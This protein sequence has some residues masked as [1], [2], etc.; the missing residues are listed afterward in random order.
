MRTSA[1]A[2]RLT[3]SSSIASRLRCLHVSK[4]WIV[5]AASTAA[6]MSGFIAFTTISAFMIPLSMEFGWQKTALSAAY[7]L[8][9]GGAALGGVLMGHVSDRINTRAICIFG[10]MVLGLGF[11]L[12]SVQESLTGFLVLHLAMGALGCACLYTPVIAAAGLW[13]EQRRGLAIGLVTAGGTM[14]QGITPLLLQPIIDGLGWKGGYLALAALFLCLVAPLMWLIEKPPVSQS[15]SQASREAA[16]PI[17]PTLGVAWLGAAAFMCCAAMATPLVH[18]VPLMIECG[19]SPGMAGGLFLTVM[20]AGTAGRILFG[21]MADRTGA[22][23]AYMLAGVLQTVTLYCFVAVGSLVPLFAI[24]AVFGFG[25]A[26]VMT[27]LNLSVREAV[28]STSVGT[29]TA[30][31]GLLAW[32]GMGAGGGIGGYFY[33]ATGTYDLSFAIAT[34]A[35]VANVILL[36]I[37]FLVTCRGIHVNRDGARRTS[38]GNSQMND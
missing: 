25:Y 5:V 26:G 9:S 30:I 8:M 34:A 37:L 28:P 1:I 20:L 35:G 13:F 15:W 12:L 16:W 17:P 21:L 18:L 27:A 36:G 23:A 33:D 3:G 14:G 6:M 4:R 22:L 38:S 32:A 31:V 11:A 24:G 7:T 29:Y 19:R 2:L 10:A